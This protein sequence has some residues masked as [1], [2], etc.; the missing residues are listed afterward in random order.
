MLNPDKIVTLLNIKASIQIISS[1]GQTNL[2]EDYYNLKAGFES[3]TTLV[4]AGYYESVVA[5]TPRWNL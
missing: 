1:N 3:G 4:D 5:V 2:S